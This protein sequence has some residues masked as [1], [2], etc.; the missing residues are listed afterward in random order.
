MEYF[1]VPIVGRKMELLTAMTEKR[2]KNIWL[3]LLKILITTGLLIFLGSKIDIEETIL[4]LLRVDLFVVVL[5]L[6]VLVVQVFFG[7]LRWHRIMQ[8]KDIILPAAECA[9]IYW[10]GLFFNQLLPSSIGG[11]T[12]R[13]Y[14]VVRS[15]YS[16]GRTI[17]SIALDRVLGIS[18]LVFVILIAIPYTIDLIR[19]EDMRQGVFVSL[20][21]VSLGLLVIFFIDFFLVRLSGWRVL[22]AF[23]T[24]ALDA[25]QLLSSR[26]GWGLLLLSCVIHVFSVIVVWLL[27]RALEIE[28]AWGS[29]MVVVPIATL[30]ATV[31]I[32]IAGWGVRESVVV[33]GLGYAGVQYEEALVLSILYGISM[34]LISLY[35][36]VLWLSNVVAAS[37]KGSNDVR[38]LL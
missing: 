7:I 28:V 27:A 18:G 8:I 24:L 14:Y 15:G 38:K 33:I 32:S 26:I 29:L 21:F 11:D 10:L 31:P 37:I 19:S 34:L 16:L 35:G 23:K 2:K 3:G 5:S 6:L 1:D 12:V 25:R 4:I 22:S 9:R 30:L 20:I 13:T 36:A 17:L